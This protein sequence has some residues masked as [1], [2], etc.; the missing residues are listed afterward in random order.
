MKTDICI[1]LF[2]S[3][4]VRAINR[5]NIGK[6][7]SME[8]T[9]TTVPPISTVFTLGSTLSNEQKVFLDHYGFLHFRGV[10]TQDEVALIET[11]QSTLEARWLNEEVSELRGV[12]IFFGPGLKG[13]EVSY[14]LPFC[15]EHSPELRN[16]LDDARFEPIKE[17]VGDDVRIGHREQDGVVINRYVNAEGSVRPGLGWHTDGLRDL[18][19]LRKPQPMLNFGLH[20]DKITAAEG[21]LRLLPG[22]HKQSLLAMMFRKP[23]F[24]S[25]RP[26]RAEIAVETEPGDMTVHDGRLWHRVA[27]NTTPGTQRRSLYVPYLTGPPVMREEGSKPVFYHRLGRWSRRRKGGR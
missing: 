10:L 15:S 18:F 25:H 12:P 23:Y 8:S 19:Y 1:E 24:V 2:P 16:L 17:L 14:R 21:G 9:S 22:T 27:Q 6:V 7:T 5:V 20:L 4:L 13:H 26:H 3:M 11:V